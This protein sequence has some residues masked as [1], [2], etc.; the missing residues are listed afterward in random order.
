MT[1][2]QHPPVIDCMLSEEHLN[3]LEFL[4]NALP[5]RVTIHDLDNFEFVA[6]QARRGVVRIEPHKDYNSGLVFTNYVGNASIL[7]TYRGPLFVTRNLA[8]EI[9]VDLTYF[10]S[11]GHQPSLVPALRI[12]LDEVMAPPAH[13]DEIDMSLHYQASRNQISNE[14]FNYL[15][16]RKQ[17]ASFLRPGLTYATGVKENWTFIEFALGE[18]VFGDG[19]LGKRFAIGIMGTN[20]I[21]RGPALHHSVRM[22][23]VDDIHMEGYRPIGL[24]DN[25]ATIPAIK[26]HVDEIKNA[27]HA[28]LLETDIL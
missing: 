8:G 20:S 27:M 24:I 18:D 26:A 3:T 11:K 15:W 9:S 25:P 28:A 1:E 4:F 13:A 23:Q 12:L 14:V 6:Q 2:Q 10:D 19:N 22:F 21:F 17:F 5:S 16:Q 7:G